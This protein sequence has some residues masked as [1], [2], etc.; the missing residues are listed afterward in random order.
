[1]KKAIFLDRDGV[2]NKAIV[3]NNRPHSPKTL[4]EVFI[5]DNVKKSIEELKANKFEIV[6]ITNQPDIAS[7]KITY[8]FV[9]SIHKILHEELNLNHFYVCPHVDTDHCE[10][11]KPKAGMIYK[12]AKDLGIDLRSSFLVGDRWKDIQAGQAAGVTSFFI[13]NKYAER[14][15]E[16]PYFTVTSLF[17]AVN[18]I[19]GWQT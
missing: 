16:Q 7:K 1:M 18:L 4:D 5:L 11:R 13:D 3:I 8:K 2:L 10:C 12:A 9:E 6:V 15:P 19:S 17:E 14:M